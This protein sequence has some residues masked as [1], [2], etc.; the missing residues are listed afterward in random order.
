M[1]RNKNPQKQMF[2]I[3][4][5]AYYDN[6]LFLA[7]TLSHGHDIGEI[8]HE[9]A[10]SIHQE[11]AA[12]S[13]KLITIKAE[14]F[15]SRSELRKHIQ[16]T[17]LLSSLG[18]EYGSQGDLDKAVRLLNRNEII[19]FFQI[20]NTLID[21]LVKHSQD[22]LKQAVLV[23]PET[24][25][26]PVYN[27]WE[28]EF[29]EAIPK[30]KLVINTPQVVLYQISPPRPIT[31]LIDLTVATQQLDHIN[32][33]SSY[34][35][36]LPT[37]KLFAVE[38][39]PN[40]DG[41]T[42]REI[43]TALMVNLLLYREI[44]FHLDPADLDNF[45]DIVYDAER[46]EIQKASKERLL[47]WIGHYLDLADKPDNVKKYAVAYWRECLRFLENEWQQGEQA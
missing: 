28:R 31:H 35:H 4:T 5:L 34:L 8:V 29:I 36:S 22:T 14:D 41:D 30:H 43:T 25:K 27:E 10:D 20:G 15:S 1:R 39:L 16:D 24:L 45:R 17:F 44:D 9:K 26:I 2:E 46:G 38:Y 12:L 40:T 33:R 37:A 21:K 13:H 23:S 3:D 19:K 11:I 47:A 18:L 6:R 32:Y 7:Q 42:A